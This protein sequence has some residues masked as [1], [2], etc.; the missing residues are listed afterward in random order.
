[1]LTLVYTTF[2]VQT[3]PSALH[4]FFFPIVVVRWCEYLQVVEFPGTTS[5]E[6]PQIWQEGAAIK[7]RVHQQGQVPGNFKHMMSGVIKHLGH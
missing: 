5:Q 4:L 7:D 3:L 6:L 2:A 1:M